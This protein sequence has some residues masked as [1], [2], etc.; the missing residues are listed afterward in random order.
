MI[1]VY[2]DDD[3]VYVLY[4]STQIQVLLID[5]Q[6]DVANEKKLHESSE[7]TVQELERKLAELKLGG[8][9][10]PKNLDASQEVARFDVFF[11]IS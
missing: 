3:Y 10:G 11:Y 1:N 8:T 9:Q 5:A 7:A 2:D 4:V 6:N